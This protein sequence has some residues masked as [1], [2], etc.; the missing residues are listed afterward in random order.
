MLKQKIL[1]FLIC[2]TLVSP[3]Y[4]GDYKKSGTTLTEDSY[5]FTVEEATDLMNKMSAL[6][7]ELEKQNQI[8]EQYKLLDQIQEEEDLTF[9]ELMNVKDLQLSQYKQLHTLDTDRIKQLNRQVN[10]SK[11]EKWFFMG[12]GAGVTIGS[13][14]IADKID[15]NIESLGKNN[16]Q[17]AGITLLRF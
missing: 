6:E 11:F 4:A 14:L 13:I 16:Q 3:A 12:L 1:S 2:L 9:T 10:S 17:Q 8:I 5:V 15:D 7:Q